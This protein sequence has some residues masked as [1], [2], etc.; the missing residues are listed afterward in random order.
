[1]R[2][3]VADSQGVEHRALRSLDEA[4]VQTDGFVVLEGDDGGQIYA[5]FPAAA[6]ECS[7]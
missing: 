2:R 7:A 5:V 4:R 6:V 3:L 1:M